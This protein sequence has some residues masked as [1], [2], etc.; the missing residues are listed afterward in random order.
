MPGIVALCAVVLTAWGLASACDGGE[1]LFPDTVSLGE[2]ELFAN[3][4]NS[5]LGTGANRLL[6]EIQDREGEPVLE[7]AVRLR[8]YDLTA[9]RPRLHDETTARFVPVELGYIDE[10]DA[11]GPTRIASG[12]SGIYVANVIFG[13]A[14]DWGLRL[15]VTAGSRSYAEFPFRFNVR[16]RT[17]EPMLG[18]PAP[19]SMQAT[20]ADA[21]I[22]EIDS[23][24]PAR[25]HMHDVT[26]ADALKRGRPLVIA[27]ATP[28]FCTSRICAPVMDTVMDPLYE[29]YRDRA[30]FIHIE[31]YVLRDLRE[32]FVRTPVPAVREWQLQSE[33]WIFVV[34]ADGRVSGKFE[35]IMALEEVEAALASALAR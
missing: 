8:L 9:D 11:D 30:S 16:E 34:D 13:Q 28:A 1:E 24:F 25:P 19:A 29:R 20:I 32:A 21:P 2:G 33:P 10:E 31:P 27:F 35:G 14:G 22:E 17:P 12:A 6:I 7:A 26:I 23:S 4:K 3:I 5:S 15:S 18:E